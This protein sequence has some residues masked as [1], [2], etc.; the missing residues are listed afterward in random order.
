MNF[1]PPIELRGLTEGYKQAAISIL[2]TAEKLE[3]QE[4]PKFSVIYH[5]FR[6]AST[7]S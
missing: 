7:N 5:P 1:A 6:R 2:W 3:S 4:I